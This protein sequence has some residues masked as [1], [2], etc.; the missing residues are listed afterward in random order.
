MNTFVR[1]CSVPWFSNSNSRCQRS[2]RSGS[3]SIPGTF[4]QAKSFN[5]DTPGILAENDH[6][7]GQHRF[8]R[9]VFTT[10]IPGYAFP[11]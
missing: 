5:S 11:G 4:P 2:N 3:G 9:M 1:V 7:P 6:A 10:I 8:R